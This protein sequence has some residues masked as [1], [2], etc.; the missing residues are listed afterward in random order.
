[1]FDES[2]KINRLKKIFIDIINQSFQGSNVLKDFNG[3]YPVSNVNA[4][5]TNLAINYTFLV[6][7]C[8]VFIPY[9]HAKDIIIRQL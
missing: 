3:Y 1:M 4:S 6:I 8:S 9:V 2:H 5:F 7:S